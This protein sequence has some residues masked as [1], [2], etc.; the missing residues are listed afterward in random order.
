MTSSS[1]AQRLPRAFTQRAIATLA[2]TL[3]NPNVIPRW[4]SIRSERA[5]R[6]FLTAAAAYVEVDESIT[7]IID[8]I[9]RDPDH[10]GSLGAPR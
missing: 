9:Q 6:A 4:R 2:F 8:F 10:F 3:A 5:R 7:H 1:N